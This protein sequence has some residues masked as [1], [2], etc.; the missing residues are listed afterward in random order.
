M[1]K[2]EL[3]P[4]VGFGPIRFGM[5]RDQVH[6]L[7]GQTS[8]RKISPSRHPTDSWHNSSL[9]IS[10][11]GPEPSVEYIELSR[12][13]EFAVSCFGHDIFFNSAEAAIAVFQSHAAV[14]SSDPEFGYSYIFPSLELS[15]WRPLKVGPESEH[16]AT[17]GIGQLGYYSKQ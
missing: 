14:D 7:L 8:L 13:R 5:R 15:L 3:I 17:V 2:I 1:R 4:L 11:G 12:S 9:Q 10:Y 6:E 16:F